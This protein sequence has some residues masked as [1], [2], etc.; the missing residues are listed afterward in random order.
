MFAPLLG[1]LEDPATGSAN[2][3]LAAYLV[4][5]RYLGSSE[6][7]IIVEQG[8]ELNRPSLLYLRAKKMK[9]NDIEVQVGGKVYIIAHGNLFYRER[10]T[11]SLSS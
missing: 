6:I 11:H 9:N 8:F 3:C 2:G 7:D 5:H 4:K 10:T 1:V